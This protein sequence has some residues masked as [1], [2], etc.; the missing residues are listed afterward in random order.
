MRRLGELGRAW[1]WKAAGWATES[2]RVTQVW[3]GDHALLLHQYLALPETKR[4]WQ[5]ADGWWGARRTKTVDLHEHMRIC[6]AYEGKLLW[7][8]P[9]WYQWRAPVFFAAGSLFVI[10]PLGLPEVTPLCT[11]LFVGTLFYSGEYVHPLAQ[12]LRNDANMAAVVS[13]WQL[14]NTEEDK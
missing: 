3:G 13:L 14:Q 11:L 4:T 10:G 2:R 8:A 9:G 5:E 12:Y 1:A 7:R 6:A